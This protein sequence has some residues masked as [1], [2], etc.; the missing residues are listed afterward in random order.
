MS[1]I[2]EA[3][4]KAQRARHDGTAPATG[5]A[6]G[7]VAKRAEPKSAKS[8]LLIAVG[9]ATL[10]VVSMVGTALWMSRSPAPHAE[11]KP[12]AVKPA[13]SAAT[14][15]PTLVVPPISAPPATTPPATTT[16]KPNPPSVKP[17]PANPAPTSPAPLASAPIATPPNAAPAVVSAPTP[18]PEPPPAA[19][20]DERVHQFVEA[21]RVTGIRASGTESKVL[22]NDRVYRVNDIVERTL[23]VRL[24]KVST[25]SLTF[26]DANGVTYVKY[27]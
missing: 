14:S 21:I 26:T 2:N 11:T 23:G 27:F 1:L 17:A 4:K 12:I 15:S 6:E 18:S 24:T 16:A 7:S 22:M 13:E 8:T 25:D 19:K 9:A 3:L 20:P 5:D 10:V